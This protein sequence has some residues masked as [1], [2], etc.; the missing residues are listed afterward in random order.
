MATTYTARKPRKAQTPA[1]QLQAAIARAQALGLSVYAAC[2]I[3]ATGEQGWL[4]PSQSVP[5]MCHVVSRAE[6]GLQCDCYAS[7][8]LGQVCTHRAVVYL[9][10]KAQAEAARSKPPAKA[11]PAPARQP[12]EAEARAAAQRREAAPLLRSDAPFSIFKSGR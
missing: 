11:Q 4:V 6:T 2:T 7:A 9:H 8:K 1:E 3:L 12:T 5:N 10:L